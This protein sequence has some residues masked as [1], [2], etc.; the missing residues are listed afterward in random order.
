MIADVNPRFGGDYI[1]T[2]AE[3]ERAFGRAAE[4]GLGQPVAG[5]TGQLLDRATPIG[6]DTPVPWSG[7]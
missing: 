1:F 5:N 4:P 3:T 6:Q 2:V 7:Q